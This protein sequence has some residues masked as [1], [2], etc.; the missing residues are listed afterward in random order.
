MFKL[1]TKISL[2]D[3]VKGIF[4][5]SIQYEVRLPS[6]D[7]SPYFGKYQN[8]KWGQW[9]SDSCWCLSA[10]NC[11]EDQL[12]WLRKNGMFSQDAL[13]FFSLHGYIDADG[14]FS[15]SER[16]IEVMSGIKDAGNNQM[17]AWI[18]MQSVGCI[19]RPMLTYSAQRASLFSTQ[20]G[21]VNDYF[22]PRVITDEMKALGKQ[23]LYYVKIERQW[24]GTP[25]KTPTIEIIKAALKQAPVQ[26]GI[27]VPRNISLYNTSALISYDG[28]VS[29]DHAVE[30]YALSPNGQYEFF[31][32]YVPNLKILSSDYY[33]P[34]VS[35]GILSAV[36]Q[37]AVNPI[38]QNTLWNRFFSAVFAWYNGVT[39]STVD[40]G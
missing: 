29:A 32:Q 12:E 36:A 40:V 33:L 10:I 25:W 15:L 5:T 38:P 39:D 26:I 28:K 9:D 27:P 14:D 31:D 21:F 7:W 1:N 37:Q 18:L 34:F 30:L 35:Q 23:F 2:T 19:P 24:I 8:Q 4:S 11:A 16:F 22:D 6:G 3:K 20:Q 13:D 17:D